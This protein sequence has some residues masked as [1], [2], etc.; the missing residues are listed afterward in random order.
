MPLTKLPFKPGFSSENS[1]YT[2]GPAWVRGDKVRF[3]KNFPQ[4]IGGWQK[5]VTATFLGKARAILGWQTLGQSNTTALGT[6]L[7]LYVLQGGTY[8]DITPIRDSGTLGSNPITTTNT[9]TSVTVNDTSHGCRAG[10]YVIFAGATIIN[11]VTLNGEFVVNSVTDANNFIVTAA[12]TAN[13]SGAGGGSSVTFKYLLTSGL[14]DSIFG[15]GWGASTWDAS[16]WGTAR[17]TSGI[18]IDARNWTLA[19]WGEDL[20][21][22]LRGGSIY[23]WD[24]S[25]GPSSNR[26]TVI[27]NAPACQAIIVSSPDRHLIALGADDG[28]G[29][30][31]K[32]FVRW[33]DQED[34][35]TW[36]PAAANTAGNL[37]LTGGSQIQGAVQTRKEIIIVTDETCHSM[38]FTGPPFTFAI[39]PVGENC[40]AVGPHSIVDLNSVVYWMGKSS[41]FMFDGALKVLPCPVHDEVFDDMDALNKEKIFAGVNQKFHEIW[42]FYASSSS[43]EC[44]SYVIYNYVE[45]TWVTGTLD[46]TVWADSGDGIGSNPIAADTSGQLF[47]H[48]DGVNDVLAAITAT[49]ESGEFEL[50]DGDRLVFIDK[51]IMDGSITG[52]IGMTLKTRRYPFDSSSEISKGPFTISSSTLKTSLRARGRQFALAFSSSAVDDDFRLGTQR[53][54]VK[55]SGRR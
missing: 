19:N 43:A 5:Y 21:S 23:T 34:N 11:N 30:I 48:E 41:F 53:L 13:S 10:D 39:E 20:I 28:S 44:D 7:K 47:S 32:M 15:L 50:G 46:R 36:A 24:A 26:A 33:S 54:N 18:V 45:R 35:T 29:T 9:S 31:D 37:L 22:N 52:S 17:S 25:A 1:D 49:L 51:H 16:T 8:Y 12:T 27:S 2:E 3:W 40:G 14:A 4:K 38:R 6:H 42:W 55:P